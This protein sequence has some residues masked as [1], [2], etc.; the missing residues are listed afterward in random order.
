MHKYGLHGKLQAKSG[1]G[2]Q[3]A[4]I[5]LEASRLVANAKGCHLYLISTD[6][7]HPD[8]VFVTEVWDSSEDH[9]AS[10]QMPEVRALIGQAMPLLDGPPQ[11]GQTLKVH[12]GLGLD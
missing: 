3:L 1:A 9:R 5:L 7:E 6:V 2:A 4:E 11:G 8:A 10:L 12:G